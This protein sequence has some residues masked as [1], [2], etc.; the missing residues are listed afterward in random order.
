M[1]SFFVSLL[2]L[3]MFYVHFCKKKKIQNLAGLLGGQQ[4]TLTVVLC[5][6]KQ[7]CSSPVQQEEVS[8]RVGFIC[9]SGKH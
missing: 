8:Q 2:V 5:G 3:V 7:D 1:S 9:K 6:L 4:Y